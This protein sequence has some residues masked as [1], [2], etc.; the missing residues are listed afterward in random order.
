MQTLCAAVP[1]YTDA[2]ARWPGARVRFSLAN[3]AGVL[4]GILHQASVPDASVKGAVLLVHGIGGSSESMYVVRAAVALLGRGFDVVRLN[5]RG[6]GDTMKESPTLYHAGLSSDID[7][8]IRG[9]SRLSRTRDLFVLGFSGGG[10]LALKM[11]GEWGDHAPSDVKGVAAMSAP[12][13]ML[14]IGRWIDGPGRAPYRFHVMRG[15][16]R[17]ARAYARTWPDLVRFDVRR[18]SRLASVHSYD[19]TVIVPMHGFSSVEAYWSAASA[20]PWLRHIRTRALLVHA[21]DDPMVPG[22]TVVP[23]LAGASPRLQ[24]RLSGRGGHLGWVSGAREDAWVG[25]WWPLRHVMA[26][27]EGS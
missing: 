23:A 21:M 10:S 20:G 1:A 22:E 2:I 24:V 27:F 13:D 9:L 8:A 12:L 15:L 14:A 18:L 17:S 26:F 16:V 3:G 25:G 7:C 6:A 19:A 4:R 11:A 5:L